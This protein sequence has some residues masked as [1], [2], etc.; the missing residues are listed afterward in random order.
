MTGHSPFTWRLGWGAEVFRVVLYALILAVFIRTF[1]FQPFN[2]PSSSMEDT[3][4]VG[5]YL[6]VTK[7]SY[8]YSKHTFPWS[9][10]LFSGRVWSGNP[11]RGD[12]AVFKLPARPSEDYIKRIVG[13]PGDRIQMIDGVLHINGVPCKM[14]RIEDFVRIS[15]YGYEERIPRFV[16]T[17]PNGVSHHILDRDPDY[18]G[19]D[20]TQEFI[21]PAGHYFMMGDN[22][23][24]SNDSRIPNSG[25]GFVP[26]ENLVGRADLI[27][28]STD[29]SAKNWE[30]WKWPAAFRY[31]RLFQSI[32]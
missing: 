29:G 10:N 3:L 16:E 8:G 5:D 26:E 7:F 12:V 6:F 11:Q 9:P 22:R 13:L 18:P 20:N 27:L 25:V 28:F 19:W 14:Q 31:S 15:P 4:L 32:E 1:L 2:I 24:Q 23:D 30:V 21:V 17:L